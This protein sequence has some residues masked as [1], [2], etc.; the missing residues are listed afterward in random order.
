MPCVSAVTICVQPG[1]MCT[2]ENF[3]QENESSRAVEEAKGF[4]CLTPRPPYGLEISSSSTFSRHPMVTVKKAPTNAH[5]SSGL[6]ASY[7]VAHARGAQGGAAS[8]AGAAAGAAN[9]A[10][11]QQRLSWSELHSLAPLTLSDLR[12]IVG[13]PKVVL[14]RSYSYFR[15]VVEAG[16]VRVFQG[17]EGQRARVDFPGRPG[18]ANPTPQDIAF[19]PG[20]KAAAE[21][22]A[23]AAPKK[24]E[25]LAGGYRKGDRVMSLIAH[26]KVQ[27]GDVGTVVGPSENNAAADRADRVS[28]DFGDDKGKWNFHAG[29]QIAAAA[30]KKDARPGEKAAA[31]KAA[32]ERRQEPAEKCIIGIKRNGDAKTKKFKIFMNDQMHKVMDA[33]I[34]SKQLDSSK[35]RFIFDGLPISRLNAPPPHL[36]GL[37][38]AVPCSPCA[39]KS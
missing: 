20:E 5:P 36:L 37:V 12:S 28:V 34:S 26:E 10:A 15:P 33:Y 14:L 6:R 30:K 1:F 8:T 38:E 13:H 23:A 18:P 3:Q 2:S 32:A 24:E 7:L 29:S 27:K 22:A 16:T 17:I 11:Y 25:G 4:W 39:S 21:K 35:V 19:A 31:E 9:S